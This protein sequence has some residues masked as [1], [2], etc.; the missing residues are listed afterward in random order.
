MLRYG[1]WILALAL[2]GGLT[3]APPGKTV[4][5]LIK[6]PVWADSK[7]G[8]ALLAKDLKAT[9]GGAESRVI[10]V[11]GPQDGLML[12]AVLDLA[13]D[14]SLAEP[15]KEALAKVRERVGLVARP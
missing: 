10:E 6:L 13:G 15:A 12:V 7:D 4:A 8:T 2:W 11:K 1:W 5:R 14:L 9:L 3:A